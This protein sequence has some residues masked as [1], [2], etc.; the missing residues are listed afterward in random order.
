MRSASR[1]WPSATGAGDDAELAIPAARLVDARGE[2]VEMD[3]FLGLPPEQAQSGEFN[4]RY[5]ESYQHACIQPSRTITKAVLWFSLPA[6]FTPETL[7]VDA[8]AGQ[9]AAWLLD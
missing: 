9:E 1:R 2:S 8:G 5:T 7:V 3:Q 6:G 4:S